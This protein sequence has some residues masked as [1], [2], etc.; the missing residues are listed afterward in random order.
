MGVII[1][2][3]LAA[4]LFY[5]L[6]LDKRIAILSIILFFIIGISTHHPFVSPLL[7]MSIYMMGVF[8][9]TYYP[10]FLYKPIPKWITWTAVAMF[11]LCVWYNHEYDSMLSVN[12]RH[13]FSVF[14]YLGVYDLFDNKLHFKKHDIY[15]YSFFLYAA[16]YFPLHVAQRYIISNINNEAT[17]WIAYLVVPPIVVIY[18]VSLAYLLDKKIPCLYKLLGGR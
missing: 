6:S 13:W 9:G 17:C 8:L 18:C 10:D 5:L 1:I 7:W 3:A 14:F 16:H 12:L 4:P 11:P 15:K 2:Y